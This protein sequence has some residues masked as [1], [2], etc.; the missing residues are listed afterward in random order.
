MIRIKFKASR[1]LFL[2]LI[3]SFFSSGYAQI[4]FPDFKAVN[5]LRFNGTAIQKDSLLQL[6]DFLKGNEAGSVWYTTKQSMK[7]GFETVF[8][9][10]I[11]P[12]SA[13]HGD[14]FAFVIQNDSIK[15]DTA[16]GQAGEY[17]GYAGLCNA[18]AI[19]F[20]TFKNVAEADPDA[21]HVGVMIHNAMFD[22]FI[23]PDHS[24]ALATVGDADLPTIMADDQIHKVKIAYNGKTLLVSMDDQQIVS[25]DVD[26]ALIL[27]DKNEAWV[28]F[29]GG[30]GNAMEM[31]AILNWT[32]KLGSS[33]IFYPSSKG[34]ERI[35]EIWVKS[36]DP[37]R[38]YYALPKAQYVNFSLFDLEGKRIAILD[39]GN[40]NQGTHNVNFSC[41]SLTSGRYFLYLAGE[42]TNIAIPYEVIR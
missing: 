5:G 13:N 10:Q 22:L 40:R 36:N 16:L 9:F 25:A 7:N 3:A 33:S 42:R 14:G 11:T 21:N 41:Q 18:L 30:T 8:E 39:Q 34:A 28:G 20:D 19:E 38:V 31:H 29:T 1:M 27:G 35:G 4:N 26:L 32:F 23:T 2:S 17:M 24:G 12:G 37:N 15:Q 6:T